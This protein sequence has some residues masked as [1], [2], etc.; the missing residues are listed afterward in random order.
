MAKN[1]SELR[2]TSKSRVV[3]AKEYQRQIAKLQAERERLY[4][5]ALKALK[6]PDDNQA[7]DFLMGNQGGYNVFLEKLK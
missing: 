1:F 2:L 6:V 5:R 4:A 3:V 7:W